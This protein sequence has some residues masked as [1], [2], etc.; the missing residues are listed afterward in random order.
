[1]STEISSPV[2]TL[3][4]IAGL[5]QRGGRRG[6]I[7]SHRG[8]TVRRVRAAIAAGATPAEV[9]ALIPWGAHGSAFA[10]DRKDGWHRGVFY[11]RRRLV[12]CRD[13]VVVQVD[14]PE[15]DPEACDLSMRSDTSILGPPSMRRAPRIEERRKRRAARRLA[16]HAAP[17]AE[18]EALRQ[19][20]LAEDR[21]ALREQAAERQRKERATARRV[22]A[23]WRGLS[24][25][26][27][28]WALWSSAKEC[29]DAARN[30]WDSATHPAGW[31]FAP[32]DEGGRVSCED[33]DGPNGS[34]VWHGAGRARAEVE[35][36]EAA[37]RADAALE[38]RAE[39]FRVKGESR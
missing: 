36:E 38:E 25:E 8:N 9:L 1:M 29:V 21:L 4:S 7:D 13:R 31:R 11:R 35:A 34:R 39:S 37:E 33:E 18:R 19:R 10:T 6:H 2:H 12:D 24:A 23:W 22:R 28:A 32:G 30:A 20:L 17:P 26:D 5:P 16:V 14:Y 27:R 15:R 3:A